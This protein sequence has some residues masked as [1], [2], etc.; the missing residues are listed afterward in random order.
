MKHRNCP[1]CGAVFEMGLT[2]CKYCGTLYYDLSC[3]HLNEPFCLTIDLGNG[4]I[5]TSLV[6]MGSTKLTTEADSVPTIETEFQ[7]LY[8]LED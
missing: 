1:N 3:I 2:K 8:T 7:M 4:N 5:F 6:R